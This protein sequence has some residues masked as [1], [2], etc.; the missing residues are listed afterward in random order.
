MVPSNYGAGK[1]S[2]HK[3]FFG[4]TAQ[5][6]EFV[7]KLRFEKICKTQSFKVGLG[8]SRTKADSQLNPVYEAFLRFC[9][10]ETETIRQ[11]QYRRDSDAANLRPALEHVCGKQTQSAGKSFLRANLPY[12]PSI[13]M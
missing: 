7:K 12:V 4:Q 1:P 6:G 10:Y 11:Q 3:R 13:K 2:I 9:C 8:I 5:L